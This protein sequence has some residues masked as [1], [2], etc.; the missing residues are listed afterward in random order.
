MQGRVLHARADS[1][2]RKG[3]V[4]GPGEDD[5]RRGEKEMKYESEWEGDREGQR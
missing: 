1:Y 3:G 2:C 5:E 4:Y